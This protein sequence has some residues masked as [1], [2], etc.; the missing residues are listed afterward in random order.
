MG[1]RIFKPLCGFEQRFQNGYT[2]KILTE[3]GKECGIRSEERI[4]SNGNPYE[5]FLYTEKGQR[6]LTEILKG[7][8][9]R[10]Y[11]S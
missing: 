10:E 5:V 6:Y 11:E 2:R 9:E 3:K 4:S 8:Y 1:K 7:E